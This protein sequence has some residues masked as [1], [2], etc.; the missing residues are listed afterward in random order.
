[1][2]VAEPLVLGK[3]KHAKPTQRFKEVARQ[4]RQIVVVQRPATTSQMNKQ[5]RSCNHR[6]RKYLKKRDIDLQ[7][8]QLFLGTESCFVDTRQ[9]VVIQLPVEKRK[10]PWV[11]INICIER[12]QTAGQWKRNPPR[13]TRRQKHAEG[14]VQQPQ[15][16]SKRELI[17]DRQD[18]SVVLTS[19]YPSVLCTDRFKLPTK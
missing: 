18:E 7:N 2:A 11:D 10:E 17:F 9:L 13:K 8:F 19:V 14:R 15:Q 1:M 3:T 5:H 4:W 12:Y 16:Q 6:F